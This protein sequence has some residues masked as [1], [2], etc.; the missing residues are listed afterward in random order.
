MR[1]MLYIKIKIQ[2]NILSVNNILNYNKI[3]FLNIFIEKYHSYITHVWL[4]AYKLVSQNKI[5]ECKKKIILPPK[6]DNC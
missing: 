4:N 6:S 5:K 2:T 3:I 1:R